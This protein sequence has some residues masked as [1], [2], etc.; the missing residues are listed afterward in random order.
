MVPSDCLAAHVSRRLPGA[1]WLRLGISRTTLISRGS[2]RTM[3]EMI[4]SGPQVRRGG[5][6]T[7]LPWSGNLERPLDFG[8]GPRPGLVVSWAD[9]YT[10]Y[11]T[12]GIPNVEACLEV[13]PWEGLAFLGSR[14]FAWLLRTPLWQNAL[15]AQAEL[16]PE[17]PSEAERSR[18]RRCI[19]AVVGDAAGRRA[20]A[21]LHTPESYT[22][23]AAAAL[24]IVAKVLAGELRPGF[25]TPAGL[26][27]ADF[28]L[29]LPGVVR[30]DVV[31]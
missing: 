4:R 13:S 24:A 17:G 14:S 23:T 20:A 15:K 2:V 6:L 5:R 27:G 7:L 26:Y 25:Q 16:L 12:T 3:V 10:A 29:G 19:L 31:L 30:E 11:H 8:H 1:R 21:R 22:F 18:H 9:V 28:V